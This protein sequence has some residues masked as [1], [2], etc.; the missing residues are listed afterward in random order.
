MNNNR[1]YSEPFLEDVSL[2]GDIIAECESEMNRQKKAQNKYI[3]LNPFPD[4]SDYFLSKVCELSWGN[5]IAKCEKVI[6]RLTPRFAHLTQIANMEESEQ[7]VEHARETSIEDVVSS[8]LHTSRDELKRRVICPFHEGKS[9]NMAVYPKTNSYYCF[10]C[11]ASGDPIKFVMEYD[12]CTFK[13]AVEK[14][15]YYH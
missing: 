4:N 15:S 14:L 9:K 6:R 5:D 7:A 2:M 13:E 10:S 12:K 11:G 1:Q 8:F 3:K